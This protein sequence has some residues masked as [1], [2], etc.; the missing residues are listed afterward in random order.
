[1]GF[2]CGGEFI[3]DSDDL[4]PADDAGIRYDAECAG[5]PEEEEV[6][7]H[8]P[9]CPRRIV[10]VATALCLSSL[11]AHGATEVTGIDYPAL[12]AAIRTVESDDG[13]TS[14]N[15]YQLTERYLR[16]L[17]RITGA[18]VS[19]ARA[20]EERAEAERLMGI[21]WAYYSSRWI[22]RTGK[23][24]SAELLAKIHRVGYAGIWKRPETAAAYW[25]RVRR[26]YLSLT[27]PDEGD[28]AQV[29]GHPVRGKT[30]T[31]QQKIKRR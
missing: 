29:V 26:V 13:R 24:V 30:L 9:W 3:Q 18:S 6:E 14:A 5:Y 21:Y 28:G 11:L 25:R 17:E 12:Y 1:M 16:D 20:V 23:P 4:M 2:M 15:A 10:A 22:A 19:R 27:K 8:K 31:N 7:P